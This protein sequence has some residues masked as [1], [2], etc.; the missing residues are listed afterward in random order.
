MVTRMRVLSLGIDRE[1]EGRSNNA[2]QI[3]DAPTPPR[4]TALGIL[5]DSWAPP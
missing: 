1:R 2:T 4:Y 5:G 3:H